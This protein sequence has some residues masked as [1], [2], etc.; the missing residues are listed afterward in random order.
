MKIKIKKKMFTKN[1][2]FNQPANTSSSSSVPNASTTYINFNS[3]VQEIVNNYELVEKHSSLNEYD[4]LNL[5][6][7]YPK[8]NSINLTNQKKETKLGAASTL[9]SHYS[10]PRIYL[11]WSVINTCCSILFGCFG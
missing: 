8:P 5:P 10:L 2:Y 9:T 4:E 11:P 7:E 3:T 1:H 6:M